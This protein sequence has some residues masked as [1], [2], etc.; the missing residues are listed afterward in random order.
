MRLPCSFF[1]C[2]TRLWPEK[3]WVANLLANEES[4]T[5]APEISYDYGGRGSRRGAEREVEWE[6]RA[7]KEGEELLVSR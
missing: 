6:Q 1:F 4:D 3:R 5:T 7:D 2:N